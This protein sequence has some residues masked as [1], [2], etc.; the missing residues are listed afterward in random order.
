MPTRDESPSTDSTETVTPTAVLD[1]R[2]WNTPGRG[3]PDR[4]TFRGVQASSARRQSR[5]SGLA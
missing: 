5:A 1:E 2:V 4:L 3:V